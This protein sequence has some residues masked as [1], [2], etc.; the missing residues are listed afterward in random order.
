MITENLSTLKINKL[1]KEQYERKSSS[2][3]LDTSALYLT[4]EEDYDVV[5]KDE[6]RLLF[7]DSSMNQTG[8]ILINSWED[9]SGVPN[10]AFAGVNGDEL[11][12]LNGIASPTASTDVANKAYVDSRKNTTYSLSKAGSTIILTG[13]DGSVSSVE[14]DASSSSTSSSGMKR[15]FNTGSINTVEYKTSDNDAKIYVVT[16]KIGTDTLGRPL[17]KTATFDYMACKSF[18]KLMHVPL[19]DTYTALMQINDDDTVTFG[20]TSTSADAYTTTIAHI[21]GYY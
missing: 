5:V 3:A 15:E 18:G 8:G 10:L 13:S 6:N 19:D 14:D 20:V 9:N 17:Y 4:P 7:D 2:G 12:R 16:F 1:T 11:V 21:C